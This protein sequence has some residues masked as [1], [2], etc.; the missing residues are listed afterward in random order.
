MKV[1][2]DKLHRLR[3]QNEALGDRVHALRQRAI[4]VSA[5]AR[6]MLP[7]A[8]SRDGGNETRAFILRPWHE[9]AD[10]SR[11]D[12]EALRID[13]AGFARAMA[14]FRRADALHRE[15]D[16]LTPRLKASIALVNSIE[17]YL[18]GASL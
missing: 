5:E 1:D 13:A 15:A 10:T 16:A 8:A 4:E 17:T 18:K 14:G 9:I 11:A 3:D 7:H 6:R 2:F 12:L